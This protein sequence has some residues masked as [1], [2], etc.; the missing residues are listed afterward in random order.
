M[1]MKRKK[2]AYFRKAKSCLFHVIFRKNV[3]VLGDES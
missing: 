1:A 2:I 3:T